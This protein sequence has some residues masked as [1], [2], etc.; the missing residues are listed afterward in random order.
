MIRHRPSGRGHPYESDNEQRVPVLPVSGRS[1]QIRATSDPG[2]V[3]AI[4]E[5]DE[6]AP[7]PMD[8]RGFTGRGRRR[9][10]AELTTP[11]RYSLRYR[12]VAGDG[13]TRTRWHK[14]PI[15][16]WVEGGGWVVE[17]R[18]VGSD[19]LIHPE[20]TTT[21]DSRME[22]RS[23][24]W[25][26]SREGFHKVRFALRLEDHERLIGFGER[27]DRLDQ[28]GS[29]LDVRVYEPY[30][31]QWAD[32]RTY[33]PIPFFISSGGWGAWV[34]TSRRVGFDVGAT[35][36]DRIWVEAELEPTEPSLRVVTYQGT[37]QQILGGFL[38]DTG[39]AVAPPDWVFRPW[40]SGNEWNTQQRVMA[41][42]EKSK[43]LDIPL[44]VVVIEAWSDETSFTIFG[45]AEY[46]P[47]PDGAPHTL[48]DFTFP[49]DGAWPD[50]KGMVDLLHQD[51]IRVMLWQ[52]PLLPRKRDLTGQAFADYQAMVDRGYALR[53]ADGHPYLNQGGWFPNAL[54]LDVTNPEA[55]DWWTAKRR[56][57]VQELG[58]DGFKTDGGE[59]V[60]GDDLRYWDGRRGSEVNNE[61]PV[62]YQAVYHQLLA[63]YRDDGV[64]FSRSG[65]TGS[66]RYPAFWAGDEDSTWEAYRAAIIAGQQAGVSGI[67]FWGWD[68]AGFSGEIPDAELY[69]R[70]TAM[71]CFCPIMQYHSEYN[72]HRTP[73]RDRTPWNIAER[74][75]DDRVIPVYRK[76]AHLR[77]Q[78]VPYL[79]REAQHAIATGQPLMRPLGFDN[80]EDDEAW[81][82]PLQYR[83]GRHLLI[84]PVTEPDSRQWEVYL[85]LGD[86][87]DLWSG[88]E[89]PGPT[90][91]PVDTPLDIIPVFVT[92]EAATQVRQ[93]LHT[94]TSPAATST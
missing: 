93:E 25:L 37:P 29:R 64:T 79:S 91:L 89:V 50:P 18:E 8:A 48:A 36:P 86:W 71:A 2:V 85:P 47:H 74:T 30:K 57:L 39:P 59:H 70:A 72:H 23:I 12:I 87:V 61:Y 6:A 62:R 28:R 49:A 88:Q 35:D 38:R 81:T 84:A 20:T 78:L 75:G 14:S 52:I 60:W 54:V 53:R 7:L 77:D 67:F 66:S 21:A 10:V 27:Y 3:T 15:A 80:P 51:G 94:A 13:S 76:F 73:S 69:L 33:L 31:R 46:E 5:F 56:Y 19:L 24:S 26:R 11:M 58:I 68:I 45:D 83:L 32:N 92:A 17:D 65:F 1:L 55:V 82:H 34:A 44:G 9:W 43:T 40:M 90:V 63:K 42:V 22:A 16:D 4:V 41:E